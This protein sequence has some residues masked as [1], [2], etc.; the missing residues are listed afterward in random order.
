MLAVLGWVLLLTAEAANAQQP[1]TLRG[2]IKDSTYNYM[3]PTA[4][5]ATYRQ[6]DSALVKYTLP[7]A[8]GEFNLTGLPNDIPL[9]LV[10]SH[11][12]Y[13]PL[14]RQIP[15]QKPGTVLDLGTL[16]LDQNN[17]T[18]KEV[19]ISVVAPVRMNGDTLEFNA[20]AFKLDSSATAEDL[21]RKLPGFT[22]WGDGDI[23]FNGKKIQ[24]VLVEGKTFMGSADPA[25]ATRNLPKNALDKIQVYRQAGQKK[26]TGLHPVCQH[27]IEGKQTDRLLR[28][29]GRGLRHR[30]PLFGRWDVRWLY[31]EVAS[32]YRRCRQ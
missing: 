11:V 9:R 13:R 19:V 6:A 2:K 26:P 30:R 14:A 17:A 1:V 24:Q 15:S 31:P 8:Y 28:E 12:G 32:Q 23:T 5:I 22:I 21:I 4:T 18:L 10:I 29:R 20:D 3:L 27:P 7:D 25:I 16:Y